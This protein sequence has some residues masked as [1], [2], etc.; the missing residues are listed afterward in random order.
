MPSGVGERHDRRP[1]STRS[2]LLR[3][4]QHLPL[5]LLLR[6]SLLLLLSLLSMMYL[7]LVMCCVRVNWSSTP[8][9]GARRPS[10]TFSAASIGRTSA[11]TTTTNTPPPRLPPPPL[12]PPPLPF[13]PSLPPLLQACPLETDSAAVFS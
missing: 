8:S 6:L 9:R 12:S 13:P 1:W 3:L 10:T 7:L 2:P 11:A 4:L 5:H